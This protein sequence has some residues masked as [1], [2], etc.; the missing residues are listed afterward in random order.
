MQAVEVVKVHVNSVNYVTS[1]T[2]NCVNHV[3]SVN[4]V[5]SASS[6]QRDAASISDELFS[7]FGSWLSHKRML[8]TSVWTRCGLILGRIWEN[9]F[10][11]IPPP[12]PLLDWAV[13][14]TDE[15]DDTYDGVDSL[16]LWLAGNMVSSHMHCDK[17]LSSIY[18]CLGLG[19]CVRFEPELTLMYYPLAG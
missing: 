15:L 17:F 18:H 8:L 9:S 2:I 11:C 7:T 12:R 4:S 5:N 14:G 10:K 3:N 6:V 16:E 1:L 13:I 19:I